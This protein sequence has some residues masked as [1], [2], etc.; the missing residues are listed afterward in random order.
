MFDVS[1]IGTK[2]KLATPTG[3]HEIRFIYFCRGF[4]GDGSTKYYFD[5]I[6]FVWFVALRPKQQLHV[7]HSGTVSSLS[8]TLF[9]LC[10][11]EQAVNM[12]NHHFNQYSCTYFPCN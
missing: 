12:V 10:K 2:I 4:S 1:Y 3:G 9:F 11:L 8:H 5:F 7:C 6:C